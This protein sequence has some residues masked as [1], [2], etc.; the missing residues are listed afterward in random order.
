MLY[1]NSDLTR[2]DAQQLVDSGIVAMA[3]GE[4]VDQALEKWTAGDSALAQEYAEIRSHNEA[5]TDPKNKKHLHT[6]NILALQQMG[7]HTDLFDGEALLGKSIQWWAFV[8]CS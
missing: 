3:E 5:E 6:F 1:F 7:Q 8:C 4:T 2:L